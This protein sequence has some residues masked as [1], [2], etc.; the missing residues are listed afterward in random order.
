[1][2]EILFEHWLWTHEHQSWNYYKNIYSY[3][4]MSWEYMNLSHD[5]ESFT[6]LRS[7]HRSPFIGL[8]TSC[9]LIIK[10]EIGNCVY[11]SLNIV[12]CLI[13]LYYTSIDDLMLFNQIVWLYFSKSL[14][15]WISRTRNC[16]IVSC[17]VSLTQVLSLVFQHQPLALSDNP[18]ILVSSYLT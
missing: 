4:L 9:Y 6:S 16:K 18:L 7:K 1:M 3:I 13:L 17:V 12:F 15:P 2:L 10:H 5:R 14:V 8:L 11:L